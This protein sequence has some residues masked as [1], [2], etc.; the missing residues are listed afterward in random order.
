MHDPLASLLGAKSMLACGNN[1]L[2]ED[3]SWD[4]KTVVRAYGLAG[5]LKKGR[6]RHRRWVRM[7]STGR[8]LRIQ[9]VCTEVLR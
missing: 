3:E 5:L 7:V 2:S 8:Y 1:R 6:P 9:Y 4:R